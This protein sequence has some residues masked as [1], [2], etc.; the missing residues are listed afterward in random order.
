M[1]TGKYYQDSDMED[2][3]GLTVGSMWYDKKTN[4][5]WAVGE[6]PRGL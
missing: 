3:S 5:S 1:A 2:R 4:G 6:R